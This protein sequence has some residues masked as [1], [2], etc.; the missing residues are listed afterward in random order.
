MS[1]FKYIVLSKGNQELPVIFPSNFVHA[2]VSEALR[3]MIAMEGLSMMPEAMRTHER[4]KQDILKAVQPV[5]AG[6]VRF[7]SPR[8]YGASETLNLQSRLFED[9]ELFRTF[10]Y[11]HGLKL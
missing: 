1:D 2:H 7:D 5:S 8:V 4:V 3:A 11:F 9:D 10:P 6:F